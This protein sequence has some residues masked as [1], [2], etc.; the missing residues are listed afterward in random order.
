MRSVLSTMDEAGRSIYNRPKSGSWLKNINPGILRYEN[1]RFGEARNKIT[2]LSVKSWCKRLRGR[3][4]VHPEEFQEF[5]HLYI[6]LYRSWDENPFPTAKNSLYLIFTQTS[7]EGFCFGE[8]NT[9]VPEIREGYYLTFF[10]PWYSFY[11][12]LFS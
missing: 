7:V 3:W 4:Y 2:I 6:A 12:I 11:F 8:L 10:S 5:P 9:K 1:L